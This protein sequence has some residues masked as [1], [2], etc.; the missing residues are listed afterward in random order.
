MEQAK[1]QLQEHW[2]SLLFLVMTIVVF[3][4][5]GGDFFA[6]L[7]LVFLLGTGIM[8]TLF[9]IRHPRFMAQR[10]GY[11]AI[12]LVLVITI[13]SSIVYLAPVDPARLTFGQN[14]DSA[15]IERRRCR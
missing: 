2:K 1:K 8:V 6:A 10:L 9:T 3:I 4:I 7:W 12:V 13:I 5:K 15:D 11:G 14:A